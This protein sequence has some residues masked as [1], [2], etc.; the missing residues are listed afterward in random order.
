MNKTTTIIHPQTEAV[1]ALLPRHPSVSE[2][3]YDLLTGVIEVLMTQPKSYRQD[4]CCVTSCGSACCII[5]HMLNQQG[6]FTAERPAGHNK[7]WAASV[8]GLTYAQFTAIFYADNWPTSHNELN[9]ATPSQ[10][11]ARIEHFLRTGE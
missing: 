6:L 9:L 3:A 1:P 10:G 2:K 8:C 5:G 7:Q 4:L 11:I